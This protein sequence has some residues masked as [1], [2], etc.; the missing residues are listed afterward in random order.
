MKQEHDPSPRCSADRR[1]E[2]ETTFCLSRQEHPCNT[3]NNH[4]LKLQVVGLL[5]FLCS[6]VCYD[7]CDTIVFTSA[8]PLLR[9]RLYIAVNHV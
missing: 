6:Q 4:L 9:A 1:F 2:T 7:T 5:L 8:P 3:R